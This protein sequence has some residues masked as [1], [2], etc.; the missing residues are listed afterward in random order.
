MGT[1]PFVT[2]ESIVR[3]SGARGLL[4]SPFIDLSSELG[5]IALLRYVALQHN[6]EP[7]KEERCFINAISYLFLIQAGL[8][9]RGLIPEMHS[10]EGLRAL[11]GAARCDEWI[12]NYIE[13]IYNTEGQ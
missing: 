8:N 10:I 7:S 2:G 3:L 5:E 11:A 13:H 9:R 12:R 6:P 1:V 4:V